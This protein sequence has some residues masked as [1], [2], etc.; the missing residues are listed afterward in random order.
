MSFSEKWIMELLNQA[1]PFPIC[2]QCDLDMLCLW[3]EHPCPPFWE[4]SFDI[5]SRHSAL[6]ITVTHIYSHNLW[7][8]I[9]VAHY[10]LQ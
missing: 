4:Q 6:N 3:N 2:I 1:L 9:P 8:C 10:T 7:L 5:A